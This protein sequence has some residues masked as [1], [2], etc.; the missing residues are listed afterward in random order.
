MSVI[1]V[2]H[3][4]HSWVR[5]LL[6]VSINLVFFFP[7]S[8]TEVCDVFNNKVSSSS[9][10]QPTAMTVPCTVLG[11]FGPVLCPPIPLV[12]YNSFNSSLFSLSLHTTVLSPIPPHLKVIFPLPTNGLSLG[13]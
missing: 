4:V 6:L 3:R 10:D 2:A 9:R 7:C 11:V 1:I 8:M 5:L 13:F 12:T